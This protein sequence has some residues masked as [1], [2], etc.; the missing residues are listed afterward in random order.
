[1][2]ACRR[3]SGWCD[4][5]MMAVIIRRVFLALAP[6]RDRF[7]IVLLMD[8]F[9]AHLAT[10]V[11]DAF[12][13]CRMLPC[14][15]PSGMTGDMQSLASHVFGPFKNV[16]RERYAHARGRYLHGDAP[17]VAFIQSLR[18][19]VEEVL[20]GRSWSAAFRHDGF[21]LRQASISLLL[22][23]SLEM[24]ANISRERPT[25][26]QI[27]LC[28]GK[29]AHV[30]AAVIWRRFVVPSEAP[31]T[32]RRP[33]ASTGDGRQDAITSDLPQVVYGKTRSQ[34]RAIRN[35]PSL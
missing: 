18:D 23:L 34:T 5:E 15:V 29:R 2:C 9:R 20:M 25:L 3:K 13:R 16:L 32:R 1:M 6:L 10:K 24:R 17:M 30:A 12:S 14:V 8:S 26:S 11:L 31:S 27:E 7:Q 35:I 33:A 4:S 22:S 28:L 19:A 21:V